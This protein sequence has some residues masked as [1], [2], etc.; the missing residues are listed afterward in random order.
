MVLYRIFTESNKRMDSE[1]HEA[2]QRKFNGYTA[3]HGTGYWKGQP[4]PCLIVEIAAQGVHAS[5]V[6]DVARD[7]RARNGQ[8]T[9]LV[10]RQNID[11]VEFVRE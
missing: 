8:E 11:N 1:T 2:V 3:Y 5:D 6:L 7:I 9:V 10:T 4:E